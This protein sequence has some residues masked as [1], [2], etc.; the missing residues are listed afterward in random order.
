MGEVYRARDT[1]LDRVVAIKLLAPDAGEASSLEREARTVA[2]LSHP[3]ICTL[4]D[5]GE[6]QGRLFL[7]ME[8]IDGETLAARLRRG[9]LPFDQSLRCAQQIAQALE[10]AHRHGVVHRD[11]KPSNIVLTKAGAKLVDFGIASASAGR[12]LEHTFT[13]TGHGGEDWSGTVAYMAPERIRGSPGDALAD[14]FAFGVVLYQMLAGTRPFGGE[15]DAA[16]GAAIVSDDPPPLPGAPAAVQRLV[17]RC[18]GKDP[19]DR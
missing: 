4:H 9:P 8:F 11:L 16:V 5:V 7:V 18:L 2:G 12:A 17:Q 13:G 14:V 19:D 3:H 10:A 6:H 1:L 15:T